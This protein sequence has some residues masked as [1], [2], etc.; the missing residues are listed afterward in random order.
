[1]SVTVTVAARASDEGRAECHALLDRAFDEVGY[2]AE[3]FLGG[4]LRGFVFANTGDQSVLRPA[5]LLAHERHAQEIAAIQQRFR[6]GCADVLT[7]DPA[8]LAAGVAQV[9][10]DLGLD[11]PA[12]DA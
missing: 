9:R 10:G 3:A 8:L 4:T 11:Q 1:M 5:E 6:D 2:G 12:A 7:G